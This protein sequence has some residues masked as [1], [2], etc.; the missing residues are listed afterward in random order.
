[1]T[2]TPPRKS[3]TPLLIVG[4]LFI[5]MCVMALSNLET[6]TVKHDYISFFGTIAIEIVILTL[7]YFFLGKREKLKRERKEDLARAAEERKALEAKKQADNQ[8]PEKEV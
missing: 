5:Y 6:L 7:L 8:T 4:A 2:T 1:M 3:K